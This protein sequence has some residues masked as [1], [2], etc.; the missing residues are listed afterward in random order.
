LGQHLEETL[1]GQM[2]YPYFP[3]ALDQL[4]AM[5]RYHDLGE[6]PFDLGDV[7]AIAR[8]LNHPAWT[9]G[10]RLEVGGVT[11]V[12]ATDHE[13]H[14]HPRAEAISSGRAKPQVHPVHEEDQG[15]IRFLQGAD[16]VIHDAQYTLVEY[17]QK[18][19]WGHSPVEYA[20]DMA[21]AAQAK[22]L[23]LFHHDPLRDDEAL[24]RV[25]EACRQR[26]SAA[27]NNLEVFAAAEGDV[28]ELPEQVIV[29]APAVS[30]VEE[31]APPDMEAA[32]A[33]AETVLIVDDEPDIV[34]VLTQAL[35]P[36]GYRLLGAYDGETALRLAKAEHPS[37]I[38]LDWR[39][40][41]CHGLEVCR[42]LRAAADPQLRD[43]PVVLLTAQTGE[44]HIAAAFAAGA[45]DYLTKPFK[46]PH[47]RSRVRSWLLRTRRDPP[48]GAISGG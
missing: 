39:M 26:V 16:L 12:Y 32:T 15:H 30:M 37:L 29:S 45:T 20:V 2:Q 41:G 10:Y 23:A 19:G 4:G 14:V 42:A 3:L 24:D 38:L 31:S 43:V 11:L 22:R 17:A 9:L 8:Y 7:R 18:V 33:A 47:V 21:V 36:E 25:V 40:P 6:G 1:A 44:E 34:Q 13:P 35:A 48:G 28:I 46:L 5:I 27:H